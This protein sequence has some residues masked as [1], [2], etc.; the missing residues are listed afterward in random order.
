LEKEMMMRYTN[1]SNRVTINHHI[2]SY[3]HFSL[4]STTPTSA[5]AH[6]EV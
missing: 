4:R 5:A 6:T 3:L 2:L 1:D